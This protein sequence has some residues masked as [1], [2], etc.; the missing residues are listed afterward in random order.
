MHLPPSPSPSA[1]PTPTH[2]PTHT[3]AFA[4]AFLP[5]HSSPLALKLLTTRQLS[6]K[7]P[8]W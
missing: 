5:L 8:T 6:N 3:H 2:T 7:C 4:S 1:T